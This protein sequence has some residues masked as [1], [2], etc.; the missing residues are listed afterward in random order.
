MFEEWIPP[1]LVRW[2]TIQAETLETLR[3]QPACKCNPLFEP[4][5]PWLSRRASKHPKPYAFS[6]DA[7][8]ASELAN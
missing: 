6:V 8:H 3:S 5:V 4:D 7:K 2:K 1:G